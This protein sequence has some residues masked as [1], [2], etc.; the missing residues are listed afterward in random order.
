VRRQLRA[1]PGVTNAKVD[2]GSK[3]A[4]VTVVKGT[5]VE[6]LLEGVTGK[7]SATVKK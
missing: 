3:T 6:T 4:T 2:L 1:V 7:Y 5:P